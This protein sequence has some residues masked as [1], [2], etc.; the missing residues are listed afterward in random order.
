[1]GDP[2]VGGLGGTGSYRPVLAIRDRCVGTVQPLDLRRNGSQVGVPNDQCSQPTDQAS[3]PPSPRTWG[4]LRRRSS[5]GS[6]TCD[7]L[8]R[9]PRRRP[10]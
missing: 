3:A 8:R 7:A 9:Y 4:R 10:F 1:V 5:A 6:P 2:A